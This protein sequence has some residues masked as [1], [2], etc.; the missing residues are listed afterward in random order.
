MQPYLRMNYPYIDSLANL[1]DKYFHISLQMRNLTTQ[2]L[3]AVLIPLLPFALALEGRNSPQ[4]QSFI[5]K[6]PD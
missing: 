6:P 4:Q 5:R 3:A 1:F 2:P